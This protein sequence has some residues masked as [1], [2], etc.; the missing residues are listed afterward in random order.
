M[1]ASGHGEEPADT[2]EDERGSD[3]KAQRIRAGMGD[4]NVVE[5][6]G[7]LGKVGPRQGIVGDLDNLGKLRP[8]EELSQ[9]RSHDGG[10]RREG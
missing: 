10:R 9:T 8:G 2:T 1:C 3:G 6:S 4:G 5:D 7:V